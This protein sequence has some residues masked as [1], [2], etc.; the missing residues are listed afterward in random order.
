MPEPHE[1]AV[2]GALQDA[3]D[4]DFV[5]RLL[6]QLLQE[7]VD[8]ASPP[9]GQ[10]GARL[11]DP[12]DRAHENPLLEPEI[13][14][15]KP[16]PT[17]SRPVFKWIV[18]AAAALILI[19][20]GLVALARSGDETGSVATDVDQ[21]DSVDVP[22]EDA[23]PEPAEQT[24][25]EISTAEDVAVA[26]SFLDARNAYDGE[27]AKSLIAVDSSMVDN[28]LQSPVGGGT[29]LPAE[30]LDYVTNAQF[31]RLTGT[32]F[33]DPDCVASSPGRVVCTYKWENDWTR[34]IADDQGTDSKFVFDIAN[35]QIQHLSHTFPKVDSD[36]AIAVFDVLTFWLNQAHPDDKP[37]L[38]SFDNIP[39]RTPETLAL[40]ETHTAEFVQWIAES[41]SCE[42]VDQIDQGGRGGRRA[43]FCPAE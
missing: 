34:A 10:D 14:M 26:T 8:T 1:K 35:G 5:Q 6:D 17:P 28:L 18:G 40:W 22:T 11:G 25:P 29:Y 41:W 23:A 42:L 19:V 43:S 15:L 2:F 31:E 9:S 39:W 3:P 4:P 20:G 38:M 32:T 21:P 33:V 36:E 24:A 30:D 12:S 7:V 16:N 37:L 13:V 27:A